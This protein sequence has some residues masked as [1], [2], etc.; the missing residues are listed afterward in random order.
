MIRVRR[1]IAL[2]LGSA[3]IAS[4]QQA[5]RDTTKDVTI[6]GTVTAIGGMPIA[7]AEV[8]VQGLSRPIGTRSGAD[9]RFVIRGID[10]GRQTLAVRRIGYL[11]SVVTV[12]VPNDTVEISLVKSTPMLDTMK[13][14]ANVNVLAG[15]VIDEHNEPVPDAYVDIIGTQKEGTSSLPDGRFMFTSVRTGTVMLRVRKLGY[16]QVVH[17]VMLNGWRGIVVQLPELDK[18]LSEGKKLLQSGFSNGAQIA[19]DEAQQ[20]I[21]RR[22]Y[23]ATVVPREELDP[24]DDEPL[25]QAVGR[26]KSGGFAIRDLTDGGIN[27]CILLNGQTP[28]GGASL[29]LYNTDDVAFVEL[30][31]PGTELTNSVARQMRTAGCRASQTRSQG[32]VGV[33]YAV[34]WTR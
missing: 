15:M 1:T 31:P 12:K 8:S 26:T 24:Y 29:D 25:G 33:F 20:R 3:G 34:V 5:A 27:I 7:D 14:T 4:A 2:L 23:G 19:W 10:K 11:P 28:I 6:R 16:A 32:R 13:V 21:G 30:Y 17:G 9:G 22:R 18:R